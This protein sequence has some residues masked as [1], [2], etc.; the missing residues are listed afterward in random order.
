VDVGDAETAQSRDVVGRRVSLVTGKPVTR[1][2]FVEVQHL[3]VAGHLG[4]NR[5]GGNGPHRPVPADYRLNRAGQGGTT[6]TVNQGRHRCERQGGDGALHGEQG[7][8]Q[9][10]ESINLFDFCPTQRPSRG[11]G[12]DLDI[13]NLASPRAENLGISQPVDWER[14]VEDHG[15]GHNRPG[16]GSAPGL[17]D[18]GDPPHRKARVPAHAPPAEAATGRCPTRERTSSAARSLA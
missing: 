2:A 1:V 14:R 5:G 7:R 6:I 3:A 16:Q 11:V 18:P 15:G 17:I 4:E 10:I 9:N 8:L 12:A 13:E